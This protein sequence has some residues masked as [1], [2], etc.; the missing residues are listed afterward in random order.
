M[1][2][3]VP[4]RCA[5]LL[6]AVLAA[7]LPS[8]CGGSSGGSGGAGTPGVKPSVVALRV[9]PASAPPLPP[10][11]LAHVPAYVKALVEA[12]NAGALPAGTTFPLAATDDAAVHALDG[13]AVDTVVSWLDP[14][15]G[16][17][18][19]QAPRLGVNND[20]T[21]WFGDGWD[22]TPG[23]PPAWHGSASQGWLWVNHEFLGGAL[24]GPSNAATGQAL[25]LARWMRAEGL[26]A[27]DVEAASWGAADADTLRR[28]VKREVGGSW[29]RVER[30]P[31][32]RWAAVPHPAARRYDAT[33]DTRLRLVG[34]SLNAVGHADDGSPLAAGV[35]TGL[36]QDCAGGVTPWGTVL[37]GEEGA[38]GPYG[39]LETC[40]G[41]DNTFLPGRGFDPGADVT[42]SFAASGAS[43]FGALAD[44]NQRHERDVIGWVAEVD[45]GLAGDAAYG[46]GGA[47]A[48]HRLLGGLGRGNWESATVVVGA[49]GRPLP[50]QPLVLYAADDRRGGRI[51]KWVSAQPFTPGLDRAATRALLDAGALFAAHLEG[52]DVRTGRTLAATGLAPTAAAPGRGRW[53]RIGRAS[54]D[55]A[56]NAA[57]LG[58]PGT[59]VGQAL[60]SPTWNGIGRFA[61]DDRVKA[62]LFTACAKLGLFEWNRPEDLEWNARD[63][64]GT[65]RLVVAVTGSVGGTLL[66]GAGRLG[67]V[68]RDDALGA[69]WAVTEDVPGAPAASTGFSVVEVWAGRRGA[70]PHDAAA[71]DN[72]L[73]DREGGLW[74]ATDG[75]VGVNGVAEGLYYLDLD[76]RHVATP[77]YGKAFRVA[78]TPRDAEATGPSLTSD[79]AALFLSVQ[80]P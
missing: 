47:G 5:A 56:P 79:Q 53:V 62:C 54:T 24:P 42:P 10:G 19:P 3:H 36:A 6:G 34:A 40:W 16:D 28:R 4:L 49:D 22:A 31:G 11:S 66:D 80:H 70:D 65:P 13:L 72:L 76:P 25:T 7:G 43:T 68:A 23:D 29:V 8:G 73:L 64:S 1:R 17:P 75:N 74:F 48:G 60:D 37:S 39:A 52:F 35:A 67:G 33:S 63:P 55:E 44:P 20:F 32:G 58:A 26:L 77:A 2:R 45:P 61:T 41:G 14:L 59:T 38:S 78:T 18:G 57:A 27:N 15:T 71:P 21:A 9:D 51:Y 50:G 30:D 46:S 69:I 12:W